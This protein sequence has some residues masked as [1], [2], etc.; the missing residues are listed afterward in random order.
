MLQEEFFVSTANIKKLFD[1]RINKN[2][3]RCLLY[4]TPATSPMNCYSLYD[5]GMDSDQLEGLILKK[6]LGHLKK[7]STYAAESGANY[8][9]SYIPFKTA[10]KS[11]EE[12]KES[13]DGSDDLEI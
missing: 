9:Y 13:V 4:N 5:L 6:I 10:Y 8:K 11:F 7:T 1:E 12:Q 2:E 3:G